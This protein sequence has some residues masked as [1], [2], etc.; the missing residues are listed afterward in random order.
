MLSVSGLIL[1]VTIGLLVKLAFSNQPSPELAMKDRRPEQ[2]ADCEQLVKN[3]LLHPAS[4]KLTSP[5]T[6]TGD[7][8]A[9]RTFAWTFTSRTKDGGTGSGSAVCKA[10]NHLPIVTIEVRQV[11]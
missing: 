2:Q 11:E 5:F 1:A 9:Q 6:K 7:D 3:K 8:G 10:S 4:Y